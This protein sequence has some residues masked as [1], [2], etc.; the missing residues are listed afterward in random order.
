MA[1]LGYCPEHTLLLAQIEMDTY[2]DA[3][4]FNIIYE[5]LAH[6]VQQR[7]TDE[8]ARNELSPSRMNLFQRVQRR[9]P[10][11]SSRALQPQ[12]SCRVCQIAGFTAEQ[13]LKVLL[14]EIEAHNSQILDL[15]ADSDGLCM[16]H[17]KM[18]L[19][20]APLPAQSVLPFLLEDALN[21]LE[22]CR[23]LMDEYIRKHSWEFRHEAFTPEEEV[24][25]KKVFSFFTGLPSTV[26]EPPSNP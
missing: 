25:W 5:Q 6:Y 4:G 21:R 26:L 13:G 1:G 11:R 12:A 14:E 23:L 3:M 22:R 18:A 20:S 8:A 17:L 7:L 16:N 2:G 24:A 15:Y 19:E 10:K 9:Q